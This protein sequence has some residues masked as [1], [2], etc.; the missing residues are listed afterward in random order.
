MSPIF[1]IA[2]QSDWQAAQRIGEYRMS[3]RGQSIDQVGFIHASTADQVERTA[4]SA[5]PG[6]QDLVLLTIDQGRLAALVRFEPAPDSGELFPHL[7]GPLN[8]DAVTD[9]RPLQPGPDGVFRL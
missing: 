4:N 1:H 5:F 3:T 2:T 9:A 8:L 7:Y 6:A